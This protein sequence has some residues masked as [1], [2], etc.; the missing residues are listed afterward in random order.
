[1]AA[2]QKLP[3]E[4]TTSL[5]HRATGEKIIQCLS[6]P[7]WGCTRTRLALYDDSALLAAPLN[8]QLSAGLIAHSERG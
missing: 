1:L 4:M 5:E 7:A 6:A 8:T 3:A 2:A